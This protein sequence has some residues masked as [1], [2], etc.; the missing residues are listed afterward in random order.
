MIVPISVGIKKSVFPK[1]TE[2]YFGLR[3]LGLLGLT[4]CTTEFQQ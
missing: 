2:M 1:I 3:E 4:Y